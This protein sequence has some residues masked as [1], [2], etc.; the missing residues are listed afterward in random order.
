MHIEDIIDYINSSNKLRAGFYFELFIQHLLKSH[1]EK[2]GKEFIADYRIGR[3]RLDGYIETG[4]NQYEGPVAFDIQY[5]I[6]RMNGH[7]ISAVKQRFAELLHHSPIKYIIVIA[8]VLSIGTYYRKISSEFPN[9]IFWDN[10]E[11][12]VLMEQNAEIVDTIVDRLFRLDIENEIRKSDDD[13]KKAR[14]EVLSGIKSAYRKGD[15][16]LLLGAGVSCSAGFPDWE[17]LLNSLYANF[18]NRVFNKDTVTDDALRVITEKFIELN[19]S[20]TLA[21]ARYLKAGLSRKDSETYFISAVKKVLYGSPR[22]ASPLAEAIVNLCIPKRNGAKVKSIITYNFD[23]LIEEYLDKVK[24]DYKTIDKDGVRHDSE[25]L[26]VYHVHG[27][28]S[29]KRRSEKEVSL[30]FSEEAYHKVYSEPYHW[31]NLVQL[32]TLR[33]NNCLMIG[34][35]LNDPNLRRL[36]EIAARK[37]SEERLHYVFM[38]RLNIENFIDAD[39]KMDLVLANKVLQTHHVIQ[40]MMMSELGTTIVWFEDYDEI[41]KILDAIRK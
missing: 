38:Q 10:K 5:N 13:W 34:L 31:S 30:V 15:F 40:E 9:V 37:S 18:V 25:E 20:S 17:T 1:A 32:T 23:D 41:P 14:S 21:A 8:P 4:V 22:K 36:L 39:N 16:S 7:V 6:H 24:L 29:S 33:E 2:Q 27:F 35:S 12:D 3:W 19:N 28:I 11:I 26:P